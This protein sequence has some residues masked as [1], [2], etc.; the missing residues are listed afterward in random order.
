MT[1]ERR[2]LLGLIRSYSLEV[3]APGTYFESSGGGQTTEY[4]NI[5]R[6]CMSGHL[7]ELL[8]LHLYQELLA[9][10]PVNAVAGIVLGGC[11]L[12]S[13]LSFYSG[14]L[15]ILYVRKASKDYGRTP[16]FIEGYITK[17]SRVV[18]LDDVVSAGKSAMTAAG[19]LRTAGL[20]VRGIITVIDKRRERSEMLPD[21]TKVRA[22]FTIDELIYDGINMKTGEPLR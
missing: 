1:P 20:D 13:V 22:L 8:G 5:K 9:F 12:A 14:M 11:H 7:Y 16:G 3:S 2:K 19:H 4:F 21:G 18:L 15:D 6:A 17:G 10:G